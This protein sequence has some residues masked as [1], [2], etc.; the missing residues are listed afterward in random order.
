MIETVIMLAGLVSLGYAFNICS[1]MFWAYKS[2]KGIWRWMYGLVSF[3]LMASY[4]LSVLILFTFILT[5]LTSYTIPNVLN[6]VIGIFFASSATLIGAIMKY[7]LS[8]MASIEL[9]NT[10]SLGGK[11]KGKVG[12]KLQKEIRRLENEL[13]DA[14]RI[15]KLA[16]EKEI[17]II[18]LRKKIEKLGRK[19]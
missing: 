4:F 13:S 9:K 10:T 5:F 6:I 11:K 1:R 7:H 18:E 3:F 19:K 15:N 16:V 12:Q 8:A 14:K 17:K 2:H